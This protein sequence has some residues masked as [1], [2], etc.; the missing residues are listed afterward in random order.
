MFRSFWIYIRRQADLEKSRW[1]LWF[2]VLFGCGIGIY[3]MLP[4]EPS[5]W[6]TLGIM[7]FLIVAA[8]LFKS[9]PIILR[10][11]GV[12]AILVSG[13][14][15]VQLRAIYLS[16]EIYMINETKTYVQ[17]QIQEI[18]YN[19]N[20][21]M[22]FV[23][24]KIKNFDEQDILG[25][26]RITLRQKDND[27]MVGQCVE[28]VAKIMPPPQSQ[29]V[30]GFQF[31]RN[32]FFKNISGNG[33]ALTHAYK[34]DCKDATSLSDNL[35]EKIRNWR[36]S[37]VNR[38][39]KIL[40]G[41]DAAVVAAIVAGEQ[42]GISKKCIEAYRNSGLA[43]FLSISGLHMSLISG[44][45]FFFV[46][47][48]MAFIPNLALRFD[49]KKIAVGFAFVMSSVYLL[50]SGA[51]VPVQRAFIMTTIVLMGVLFNRKA[52]SMYSVA[53]AA[54]GVLLITPEALVGASF[55][56]SFAAVI[57]LIAFY[58]KFANKLSNWLKDK[59]DSVFM[60]GLKILTVYLLGIVIADL[61]A[62]VATLPFAVYHFNRIAIYTT[63]ANLLSGPIIG[64]LI[65]PFTLFALIFMPLGL[66]R[67]F[68][69]VVGWGVNWLNNITLW[70]SSWDS[71][72][73]QILSPPLWGFIL[74]VFG[75]L[76]LCIWERNW[77]WW[78]SALIVLGALSVCDVQLP[79]VLISDDGKVIALKGNDN[80]MVILPSRGNNFIK[81]F[82]M[83]K[84]ASKPIS[85]KYKQE[86]K[87]I[88]SGKDIKSDWLELV[89]KNDFCI[90]KDVVKIDPKGHVWVDNALI[91]NKNG[92]L[93]IYLYPGLRIVNIKDYVGNR[94]WHK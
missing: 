56:M 68:L 70:V 82:W 13:F 92:A 47:L 35:R 17:G 61:V 87:K 31:D 42:S 54:F 74:I 62:S 52:V 28:M 84:T 4:F 71:A 2:P 11:I 6:I 51:G 27:F 67:C 23:L 60:K 12:S 32:S 20:G 55:Q 86:L 15:W 76:W 7:E 18:D 3:F 34:T 83:E 36:K 66:E 81:H 88:M 39:Y 72:S 33:F 29:I 43:H 8:L 37:I 9:N 93:A 53:W 91:D 57:A 5:K 19:Q 50:I 77:R 90:Y 38:I 46:R 73:I 26:F 24:G 21:K 80:N 14:G 65:M 94:L 1:P 85:D 58:E 41:D 78:G 10:I 79:D 49:S 16:S 64:L 30:Q 75:G 44:L 48:I 40:G 25:R 89:C 59:N 22:R 69:E 45:M 63:V